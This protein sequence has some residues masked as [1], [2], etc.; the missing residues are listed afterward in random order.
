MSLPLHSEILRLFRSRAG[1]FLLESGHHGT[2][3]LDLEHLCLDL[4][5]VDRM[6]AELARRLSRYTPDI[7][8]GPMVEGAF[9]AL[10][11]A[12]HL[13]LP[14]TYAIR[15]RVSSPGLYPFRY[16]IPDALLPALRG[17][18]VAVVNDVINAGSSVRGTIAHLTDCGATVAALGALVVLGDWAERFAGAQEIP[19]DV[20]TAQPNTLWEPGDCPLCT[21]GQPLD[22]PAGFA[23]RDR[24]GDVVP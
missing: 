22:D 10:L 17:G 6:T 24:G 12:R 21:A 9:V 23:R 14:F 5:A 20:L 7:V 16:R 18:R 15:E 11:V 1:H 4:A 19:L 2:L 3:W 13:D 8:C